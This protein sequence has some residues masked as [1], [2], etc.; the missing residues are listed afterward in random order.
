MNMKY[1]HYATAF[2]FKVFNRKFKYGRNVKV[3]P[4]AFIARGGPVN[5]GDNVVIRAGAML[6]PSGGSISIGQGSS[7]NHYSV[8]N[9]YGGVRIGE[10]VLIAAMVSIFSSKH[11]F[12]DRNIAITKQG[13]ST[14]GGVTI[15]DDVW[16]GTQCTIL[17]GVTIGKGCVV[18]AGTVVTKN[19]P[20]FSIIAGVPAKIIGTRK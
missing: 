12:E 2:I 6:L 20:S 7:V 3:D 19:V 18:A 17:D 10:N 16:I 1:I 15:E 14:K 4:R 5:L 13:M 8:I 11:N 9:G